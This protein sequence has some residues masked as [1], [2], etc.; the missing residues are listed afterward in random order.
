MENNQYR[1]GKITTSTKLAD[2]FLDV[3]IHEASENEKNFGTLYF[4]IEITTPWFPATEIAKKIQKTVID[5]FYGGKHYENPE[6]RFEDAI[7]KT[8]L[9]LAD[10]AKNGE[11]SWVGNLNAVIF[12]ISEDNIYATS[13]GNAKAYLL[14]KNSLQN[15]FDE[16]TNPHSP[17]STFTNIISGNLESEDKLFLSNAELLRNLNQE[18]LKAILMSFDPVTGVHEIAKILKKSKINNVNSIFLESISS[19][20]AAFQ[21]P[22]DLS[23]TV[24]LDQREE[25]WFEKALKKTQPAFSSASNNV[26]SSL[27]TT[28]KK[29]A[30][31]L[32]K[33]TIAVGKLTISIG[34][35]AEKLFE[36]LTKSRRE[37]A[38]D[39]IHTGKEKEWDEFIERPARGHKP[40]SQNANDTFKSIISWIINY[41]K[42]LIIFLLVIVL[43]WGITLIKHNVS[44]PKLNTTALIQQAQ[45]KENTAKSQLASNNKNSAR[46]NFIDG[47]NILNPAI[48]SSQKNDVQ[49]AYN[50]IQGELDNMDNIKR[51]S[52]TNP[53]FKFS[54]QDSAPQV[55]QILL[56]AKSFY[57]AN[58]Q[59]NKIYKIS[60][61]DFS[62]QNTAQIPITAGKIQTSTISSDSIIFKTN[63]QNVFLE[64]FKTNNLT[65]QK[66]SS[67]SSWKNV[68][69]IFSYSNAIYFLSPIENQIFKYTKGSASSAW[70]DPTNVIT[71]TTTNISK[72][73]SM[74]ID[75]YIYLLNSDGT[76]MKLSKGKPLA[77]FALTNLPLPASKIENPLSIFTT[78]DINSFYILDGKSKRIIEFDKNGA[79]MDQYYL[80]SGIGDVRDFTINPLTKKLYVLNSNNIYSFSL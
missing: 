49:S 47:L 80:P 4:L 71:S 59:N 64:N 76:A 15:I 48:N 72:S 78:T 61:T 10:F 12:A 35:Q 56:N 7:K 67:G 37:K 33:F 45:A 27:S 44:T 8:N 74:T 20:K 34:Q 13:S 28:G 55:S 14:R 70:N 18:Q 69:N 2:R 32:R 43:I 62:V 22:A 16:D 58:M 1:I 46:T 65:Q 23:N 9:M 41:R 36:N 25:M 51:L 17:I 73:V 30:P 29:T 26:K 5:N 75:G 66:L 40:F 79:Y 31:F 6:I 42:L 3:K 24:I 50:R 21:P 39:R 38:R 57:S 68:S 19:D 77:N 11:T 54:S 52:S 60:E 63:S 53:V